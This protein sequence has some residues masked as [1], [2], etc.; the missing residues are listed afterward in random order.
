MR[1]RGSPRVFARAEEKEERKARHVGNGQIE[2]GTRENS[3][4]HGVTENGNRNGFYT[5]GR[6]VGAGIAG[7]HPLEAKINSTLW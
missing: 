7:E 1:R 2:G 6:V 3:L 5:M 4:L